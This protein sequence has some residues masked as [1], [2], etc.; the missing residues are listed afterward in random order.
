MIETAE[1]LNIEAINLASQGKFSEAIACFKRALVMER[2]NNLL[3]Y[4]LGITYQESGDLEGAKEAMLKAYAIDSSD[5]D[6]LDCLALICFTMK[7][8][9]ESE[10]F[11]LQALKIN[12]KNARI[13]NTL[14]V[15]YFNQSVF[16]SAQE[17]FERALTINPFYYDA[18][19]NLRDTYNQLGNK[20]GYEE[21]KNKLKSIKRSDYN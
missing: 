5:Q 1:K 13:W 4:N 14:G 6:V 10:M 12:P 18:L 9:I 2:D 15:V 21:C 3:W 16:T 17:A 7:N 19:Y 11:C 8:L 20:V